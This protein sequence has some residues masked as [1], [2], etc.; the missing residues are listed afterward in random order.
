MIGVLKYSL[1][2]ALLAVR[3]AVAAEEKA[4]ALRFH[5]FL[6]SLEIAPVLLAADRHYP[7]GI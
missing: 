6:E 1:V 3:I 7:H 2:L 4:P 5:G